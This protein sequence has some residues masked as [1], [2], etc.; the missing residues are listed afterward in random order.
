MKR[1]DFLV[2]TSA[3]AVAACLPPEKRAQAAPLEIEVWHDFICPWCRIGLHNLGVVLADWKGPRVEV[4]LH[5]YLLNPDTP[6]EGRDLRAELDGKYGRGTGVADRMFTRV[7]QAGARHGVRFRW[8]KVRVSPRTAPAH[9][10]VS[11]LEPGAQWRLLEAL[12]VAYFEEGENFGDLDVLARIA[13]KAGVDEKR[14]RSLASDP[15]RLRIVR[16]QAARAPSLGI[17]GV[18]HF[19]IGDEV[20]RGAQ[21]P[22][23]LREAIE[24]LAATKKAAS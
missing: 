16:E 4:R 5:P 18:P 13:A 22:S 1:R 21:P 23:A 20:I 9:A 11:G 10:L 15:E 24:K 17:R 19:R 6:P 12:H 8:E 3:A 14:A 7:S 2:L